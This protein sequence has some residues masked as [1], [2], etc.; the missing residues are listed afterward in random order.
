LL[1]SVRSAAEAHEALAGGA[2]L[3]DVK[4][5]QQ[6]PLGRAADEVIMAVIDAVA[7]RCPVS[8]ALGELVED[9]GEVVPPGL[10]FVKWGLAGYGQSAAW[11][12][13]LE[14][15]LETSRP[16]PRAV[17]VAYADWQCARAPSVE[18]VVAFTTARRGGVLLV[19]THCKVAP[20]RGGARPTL[21][22]WMSRVEI[23]A[24]C[25]CC[26]AA[27]V[28]VALAGSLGPPEIR[29]LLLARPDWF[30][31]RGA[32]CREGRDGSVCADRVSELLQVTRESASLTRAG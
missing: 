27:H 13:A 31:V 17:A 24:L 1:V 20:T 26:R 9:R 8:A 15:K 29:E 32:A 11:Q 19:D 14:G 5:P 18:D 16:W 23:E 28:R 30:A 4:D 10:A 3:I 25:A 22:D 2:T 21:L 6:G 12:A 7:G